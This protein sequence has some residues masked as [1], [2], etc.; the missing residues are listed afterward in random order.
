MMRLRN[1]LAACAAICTVMLAGAARAE[2]AMWVVKDADSTLYLFGT[3]HILRPQTVWRTPKIDAAIAQASE[4]WLEI[5]EPKDPAMLQAVLGPLMA[6]HGL[7]IDRPLS[8]RLTPAEVATLQKAVSAAKMPGLDMATVNLMRPWLAATLLSVGPLEA[9][10]YDTAS[11][12]EKVLEKAAS[13]QGDQ[14]RSFEAVE[15]QLLFLATLPD[16]VQLQFLR[17][18]LSDTD[19]GEMDKTVAAWAAGDVA[20]LERTV[21]ADMKAEAPQLYEVLV[22]RR[23]EDWAGQIETRLKGSGV[24]FMAVGAAHLIGPDSVQAKLKLRGIEAQRF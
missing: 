18:T 6:Q 10:G 24:S 23:N 5:I 20:T 11:G 15:Q 1:G 2:P 17:D 7:S 21:V 14:I 12:V 4:L 16:D 9:A 22:V 19:V 3:V 8:S 13:S